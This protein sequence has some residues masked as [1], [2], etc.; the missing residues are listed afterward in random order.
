MT[1]AERLR[2]INASAEDSKYWSIEAYVRNIKGKMER[3][4]QQGLRGMFWVPSVDLGAG[5]LVPDRK[6]MELIA[7]R[8]RDEGVHVKI[9]RNEKVLDI[10]WEEQSWCIIM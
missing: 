6:R 2:A 9:S 8:L 1:T 10:N 3:C 5:N 7:Q 4:A